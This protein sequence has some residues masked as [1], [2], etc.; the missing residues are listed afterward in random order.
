MKLFAA[1][2]L[3]ALAPLAAAEPRPAPRPGL[4][5]NVLFII[6][7]DL[8]T[9]LGAYGGAAQTPNLDRLAKRGVRFDRAYVQVPLCN[10]SR[11]SMLTGRQ[12]TRTGVYGNRQWVGD[13][14]PDWV[15]LPRYFKDHGYVTVRSGKVF[16]GGIDDTEAWT[17]GGEARRFGEDAEAPRPTPRNEEER[18][19]GVTARDRARAPLSDRWEAVEGDTAS[20]GDT[21]VADRTIAALRKHR[22]GD[23]PFFITCG[24]SKPH[25]PLVA[26]KRFFDLYRPDAVAL[27]PDFAPRP[28]VPEG[29]PAGSIRPRNADLFIGRD[30]T[31]QGAREMIRA[32]RA[33][34][35]YM[36]WNAGRVLDE[37]ATLGLDKDTIVVFWGDHGYQLGEKGKWSKAGSLWEQGTRSPLIVYDPRSKGNGK[38][39]PRI[40]QAVDIYPTLTDL[41]G[42]PAPAD[43]DGVSLRPLLHKPEARWD[44]PAFSVWS[45]RG[46]KL[47]GV[48]VRTEGWRYAEF[49]GMGMGAMLLDVRKDPHEMKNVVEDKRH[50]KVVAELSARVRQYAAGLTEPAPAEATPAAS[51]Q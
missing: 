8:R 44:R 51:P 37:L 3:V 5:P 14:H 43:L 46:E 26:P 29:F 21:R 28:T 7:D 2:L 6:S 24:F 1:L 4:R 31:P 10:P 41:C 30:A 9:E 45:E 38:A 48:A 33:C 18:V 40:V 16:H 20:M 17:E 39:S 15:S 11:T 34:V 25:S 32:Y 23:R 19:A 47:S 12:P 49:Y 13:T 42:L 35:S 50:A 36:D 22:G 27:P